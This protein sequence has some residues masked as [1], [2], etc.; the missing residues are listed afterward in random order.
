MHR[1]VPF[2]VSP[3]RHHYTIPREVSTFL[4][5]GE[6]EENLALTV[7]E[8]AYAHYLVLFFIHPHLTASFWGLEK[9]LR[10]SC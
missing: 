10:I 8:G 2:F 9:G 5:F 4:Y 6:G 1:S 3:S 7:L